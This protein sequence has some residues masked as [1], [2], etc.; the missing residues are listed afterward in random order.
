MKQINE[1]EQQALNF[2]EQTNTSFEVRFLKHDF[3]FPDDKEKR[4]IYKI[5]LT[6]GE[7]TYKFKFGQSINGSGLRL[8]HKSGERTKYKPFFIPEELR[9]IEDNRTRTKKIR[10]YFETNYFMLAGLNY[11]LGE[12]PTSYDV[13]ASLHKYNV[14]TF[15]DFCSEFGYVQDSRKAEQTYKAV[16]DEYNNLKMLYSD[17]ELE[18]MQEI[19]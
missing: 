7:R 19:Q 16:L 4:D 8:F 17:K 1:Y 12:K 11:D 9:N 2:L 14:G 10:F 13:L 5:T 6:R 3:Y 18:K 15:G